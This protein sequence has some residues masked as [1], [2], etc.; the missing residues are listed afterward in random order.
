MEAISYPPTAI[1]LKPGSGSLKASY[2]RR[3]IPLSFKGN[4][5][6]SSLE[7]PKLVSNMETGLA[8]SQLAKEISWYSPL[9]NRTRISVG[10]SPTCSMKCP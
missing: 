6:I 3:K 7:M 4:L 9:L 5:A 2:A 8:P 10:S 1:R